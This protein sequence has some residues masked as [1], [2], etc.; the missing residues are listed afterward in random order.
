MMF[1]YAH[2]PPP[3]MD[4]IFHFP[5]LPNNEI[6]AGNVYR[7]RENCKIE[8]ELTRYR[9]VNCEAKPKKTDGDL[10]QLKTSLPPKKERL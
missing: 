4:D 6:K 5:A 7:R 8:T 2:V 10:T 9:E 1:I 3:S